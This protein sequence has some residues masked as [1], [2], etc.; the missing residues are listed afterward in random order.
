MMELLGNEMG[1]SGPGENSTDPRSRT[2]MGKARQYLKKSNAEFNE[3]NETIGVVIKS[4]SKSKF[5][6]LPKITFLPTAS[7]DKMAI[8]KEQTKAKKS[9]KNY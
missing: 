3:T 5:N 7:R 2:V 4:S 9:K 8:Y 6:L 1:F